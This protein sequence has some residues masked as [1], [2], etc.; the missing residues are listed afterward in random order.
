M[1]HHHQQYQ[2]PGDQLPP[3]ERYHPNADDR[4]QP[5]DVGDEPSEAGELSRSSRSRSRSV[6][7][8]SRSRSRSASQS[9]PQAQLRSRSRSPSRSVS[10]GALHP[11]LQ[12]AY[13]QPVSRSQSPN[14][15]VQPLASSAPHANGTAEA[16]QQQSDAAD[17]H[18]AVAEEMP[19][20]AAASTGPMQRSDF[21]EADAA[22][23]DIDRNF[24]APA[25]RHTRDDSAPAVQSMHHDRLDRSEPAHDKAGQDRAASGQQ[26]RPA[27]ADAAQQ[28]DRRAHDRQH[29]MHY[30]ERTEPRQ[31]THGRDES[32]RDRRHHHRCVELSP[33]ALHCLHAV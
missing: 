7:Q 13:D 8:R 29:D 3:D 14:P 20:A 24:E 33:Q 27:Q 32:H 9:G 6:G 26:D 30:P 12:P 28:S 2:Q 16:H 19:E 1:M 4:Y 18:T 17:L 10:G 21:R 25:D 23:K 11:A 5:P 15:A 31:V 22:A